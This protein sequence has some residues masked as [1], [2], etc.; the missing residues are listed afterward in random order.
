M[1]S[2]QEYIIG[3][4]SNLIAKLLYILTERLLDPLMN[5]FVVFNWIFY[6]NRSQLCYKSN[7]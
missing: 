5:Y 4:F 2:Q 6:P 1:K 3:Y 7:H